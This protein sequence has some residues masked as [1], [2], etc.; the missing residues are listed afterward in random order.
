MFSILYF[1]VLFDS[2][3]QLETYFLNRINASEDE[4]LDLTEWVIQDYID[5]PLQLINY[6]KR[7]F[8]LRVYV[9]AVGNLNVY[10]YEVYF[11]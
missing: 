3:F 11:N 4:K 5:N 6:N 10:V 2:R 8:H 7:K 1:Q 9:L